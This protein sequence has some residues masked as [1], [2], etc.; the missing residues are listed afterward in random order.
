MNNDEAY[1]RSLPQEQQQEWV[2]STVD[3][4][5]DAFKIEGKRQKEQ[6]AHKLGVSGEGA[7]KN[8]IYKHK[9]P[10]PAL[11]TCSRQ[12]GVDFMWLLYG[13]MENQRKKKELDATLDELVGQ[14]ANTLFNAK[15]FGILEKDDGIDTVA[16]GI[17]DDV[18]RSLRGVDII[19]YGDNGEP[20]LV[21]ESKSAANSGR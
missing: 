19:A 16:H 1:L 18:K 13:E 2:K 9:M 21:F 4:M 17:V 8:W 12:T 20:I 15:R 11:V 14:V 10:Y 6:L 5:I 3:R 7:I